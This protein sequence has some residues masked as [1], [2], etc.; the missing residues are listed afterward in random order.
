MS[1][2]LLLIIISFVI[3]CS[4]TGCGKNKNEDDSALDTIRDAMNKVYENE[5]LLTTNNVQKYMEGN[6]IIVEAPEDTA[7]QSIPVELNPETA[8]VEWTTMFITA[9]NSKN[10]ICKDLRIFRNEE[11]KLYVGSESAAYGQK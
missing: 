6:W 1:K 8:D 5:E 2:K 4:F 7:R 10:G 3:L 9:C 11:G